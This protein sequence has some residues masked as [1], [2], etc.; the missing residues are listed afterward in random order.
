MSSITEVEKILTD[1]IHDWEEI[2]QQK[3]DENCE[4][5]IFI[6][7]NYCS[8]VFEIYNYIEIYVARENNGTVEI[9]RKFMMDYSEIEKELT[10][11]PDKYRFTDLS[12]KRYND[13]KAVFL[14]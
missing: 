5:D 7:A 2:F 13:L 10:D 1:N 14:L 9:D 4:L 6:W 11:M 8:G 12:T 3:K